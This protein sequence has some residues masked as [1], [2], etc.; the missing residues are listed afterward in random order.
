MPTVC[1]DWTPY[2]SDESQVVCFQPPTYP[3]PKYPDMGPELHDRV[4]LAEESRDARIARG[5]T[6][7][8]AIETEIVGLTIVLLSQDDQATVGAWLKEHDVTQ[9]PGVDEDSGIYH[10]G[11]EVPIV[12]YGTLFEMDGIRHIEEPGLIFEPDRV[13]EPDIEPDDQANGGN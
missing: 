2:G 9:Y 1:N 3:T 12:L 5:D 8:A 4:L 13:M 7:P 11:A 6:K 10:I